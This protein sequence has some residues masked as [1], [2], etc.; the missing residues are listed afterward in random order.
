MFTNINLK[1]STII[2]RSK[3]LTIKKNI[4]IQ[5]RLFEYLEILSVLTNAFLSFQLFIFGVSNFVLKL[6]F[7]VIKIVF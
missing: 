5:Y 6:C 1:I 7:S 3:K 2:F 4:Q